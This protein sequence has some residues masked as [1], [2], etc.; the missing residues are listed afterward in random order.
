[1][2]SQQGIF[3]NI[4]YDLDD[5]AKSKMQSA[6]ESWNLIFAMEC[7]P[8]ETPRYVKCAKAFEDFMKNA[9]KRF[10]N[11]RLKA[12]NIGVMDAVETKLSAV[13][14]ELLVNDDA[15]CICLDVYHKIFSTYFAKS[16]E[17]LIQK[18]E[19]KMKQNCKEGCPYL[20]EVIFKQTGTHNS[21][22][23]FAAG[24]EDWQTSEV[25]AYARFNNVLIYTPD[26]NNEPNMSS[27]MWK[28]CKLKH[29]DFMET[30]QTSVGKAY[31]RMYGGD[32]VK[33]MDRV[34]LSARGMHQV[35]GEPI[36]DCQ[37]DDQGGVSLKE[38]KEHMARFKTPALRTGFSLTGEC[39]VVYYFTPIPAYSDK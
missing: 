2:D 27:K 16:E 30:D 18:I 24:L 19:Q 9:D 20:W 36:I 10:F 3:L 5:I 11:N 34:Y 39:G 12:A 1:M 37:Y 17:A 15:D 7:D 31:Y 33:F 4:K 13:V 21:N 14:M 38:F 26:P 32:E 8:V 35:T 25:D 23:C 29:K 22:R 6:F 28:A